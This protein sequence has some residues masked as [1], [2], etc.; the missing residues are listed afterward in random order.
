MG[1]QKNFEMWNADREINSKVKSPA[2]AKAS[3]G[4]PAYAEAPAGRPA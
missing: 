4:K 2:C 3:A 1:R